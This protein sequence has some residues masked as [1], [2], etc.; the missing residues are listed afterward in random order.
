MKIQFFHFLKE[1]LK[2][3]KITSLWLNWKDLKMFFL[4]LLVNCYLGVCSLSRTLGFLCFP[5]ACHYSHCGLRV[6]GKLSRPTFVSGTLC[7]VSA[8]CSHFCLDVN[9]FATGFHRCGPNSV[10]VNLVG[11]YRCECRSGY[12]FADDQHTCICEYQNPFSLQLGGC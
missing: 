3:S 4:V 5:F 11:S 8:F 10:C 7:L 6:L 9:E 12:E 1:F 2:Y